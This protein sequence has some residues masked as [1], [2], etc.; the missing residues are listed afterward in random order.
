[1]SCRWASV[2]ALMIVLFACELIAEKAGPETKVAPKTKVALQ[3]PQQWLVFGPFAEDIK[4]EKV[5]WKAYPEKGTLEIQ[6]KTFKAHEVK[7]GKGEIDFR[8]VF[9]KPSSERALKA[10]EQALIFGI[11][12]SDASGML[13]AGVGADWWLDWRVQGQRVVST[14]AHGNGRQALSYSNH[15][16]KVDVDRGDVLF[17][18]LVKSGSLGWKL[19]VGGGSESAWKVLDDAELERQKRLEEIVKRGER[20]LENSRMKLVIFGSSVAHGY[21]AKNSYGWGN[22]LAEQLRKRN[23]EVVN[24]SI[25]GDNTSLILARIH[26]D[27]IP[28]KPDVVVIGLSLANE[29][30]QGGKKGQTYRGFIKNMKKII[31]ICRKNGITPVV[32]N[33]YPNDSYKALHYDY[34]K[35]FNEDL[36]TWPI[37]SIDLMG[38]I[39]DG[40]GRWVKGYAKDAGHP[41]DLGH[42]EMTRAV[43]LSVFDGLI[44]DGLEDLVLSPMWSGA[45]G[46]RHQHWECVADRQCHSNTVGFE[47]RVSK[48]LKHAPLM[49]LGPWSLALKNGK[50]ECR[51]Y[52]QILPL[53]QSF[54]LREKD[55]YWLSQLA[56]VYSY[57]RQSLSLYVDGQVEEHTVDHL[58][59][60]TFSLYPRSSEHQLRNAF[61]YY[62]ARSKRQLDLLFGSRRV[63]KSSLALLAPL[64]DQVFA[65]EAP[66]LNLAPTD[67]G[68]VEVK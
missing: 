39:D 19:K 51:Q 63:A 46:E 56:L 20:I 35:K 26:R 34:V 61:W 42:E 66:L 17:S 3:W 13:Y 53:G 31:Q 10:G 48:A 18:G 36:E 12:Q 50:I 47:M 32:A 33:C 8:K 41:N 2:C 49:S 16:F 38:A 11:A 22:R 5:D 25:G 37:Y 45:L 40:Q 21:G 44:E 29:G 52:G 1:M 4:L 15:A 67:M 6:G 59:M 23:W 68:F 7:A 30:I 27:L 60:D 55:G 57:G 14:L 54:S 58:E 9:S 24:R 64:D 65:P 43:P 28:E 62:S